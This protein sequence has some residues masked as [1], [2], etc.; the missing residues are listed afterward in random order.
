MLFL[1]LKENAKVRIS[2]LD[3]TPEISFTTYQ[4][5][6]HYDPNILVKKKKIKSFVKK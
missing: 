1:H 6:W 2:P 3:D 4:M 5:T